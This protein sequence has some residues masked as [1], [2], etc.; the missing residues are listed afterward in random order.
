MNDEELK[1]FKTMMRG[2]F[3]NLPSSKVLVIHADKN[4]AISMNPNKVG[5]IWSE[6]NGDNKRLFD[7]LKVTY[8]GFTFMAYDKE[9]M[10][11]DY[12]DIESYEVV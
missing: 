11:I 6:G 2:I 3:S 4:Y 8:F 12:G 1:S 10:S 5:F 9:I 7:D